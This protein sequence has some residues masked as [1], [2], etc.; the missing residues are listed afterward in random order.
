MEGGGELPPLDGPVM[1]Y[2]KASAGEGGMDAQVQGRL[3]L[4]GDCLYLDGEERYPVVW[5]AGTTWDTERPAVVSRTGAL[6]PVGTD[7]SGSGGYL[8]LADVERVLGADAAQLAEHCLDNAYG[9][10]AFYNNASGDVGPAA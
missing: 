8:Y 2:P 7:V 3:V 1:R 4:E 6:L 10:V 9:E 5:P